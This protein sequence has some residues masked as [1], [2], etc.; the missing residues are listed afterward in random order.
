MSEVGWKMRVSS[1]EFA[2]LDALCRQLDIAYS[3]AYRLAVEWH[4]ARTGLE[5]ES[6]GSHICRYFPLRP[7]QVSVKIAR[8]D[9][10]AQEYREARVYRSAARAAFEFWLAAG[11]PLPPGQAIR[12]TTAKRPAARSGVMVPCERPARRLRSGNRDEWC[13]P[14]HGF[15]AECQAQSIWPLGHRVQVGSITGRPYVVTQ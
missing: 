15:A 2:R 10:W 9:K 14:R 4:A 13:A 1:E 8:S 11:A 3:A 12:A 6:T 7:G 5:L